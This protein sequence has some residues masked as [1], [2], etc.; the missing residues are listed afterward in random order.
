MIETR[1]EKRLR[2]TL[3]RTAHQ[4]PSADMVCGH[5]GSVVYAFA[6]VCMYVCACVLPV[7]RAYVC[8]C[9]RCGLSTL[10]TSRSSRATSM[11][12]D[13]LY[14]LGAYGGKTLTVPPAVDGERERKGV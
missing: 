13:P 8:D 6:C 3:S 4:S 10:P 14:G 7:V 9:L 2:D 11:E 12:K 1:G 5:L